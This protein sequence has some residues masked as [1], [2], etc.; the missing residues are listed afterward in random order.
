MDTLPR[1]DVAARLRRVEFLGAEWGLL[2]RLESECGVQVLAVQGM[3]NGRIE[4]RLTTDMAV[5]V[6]T[7]QMPTDAEIRLGRAPF[8]T[9]G[10]LSLIAP[11]CSLK[12][13]GRGPFTSSYCAYSRGFFARLS[14]TESRLRISEF[15]LAGPIESERLTYLGQ[16]MLREAIAP[17]FG[18]AVF[19]EA[20]GIAVAVEIARMDGGRGLYDEPRLGALAPWQMRR[21][22]AYVRANLSDALTLRELAL[23]VGV[24]VRGLSNAVKRSYGV[25]L[26]RWV[27]RQRIA[28]ARRLLDETDLP[29]DEVGRRCAFASV[30]AFSAAFRRAAGCGPGAFRRLKQDKA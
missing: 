11:G 12:L 21:L 3:P 14:E 29:I 6:H 26:N 22:D 30:A 10:S 15:N 28:Q 24:S 2:G 20:M 7:P 9:L 19:A 27:A 18:G 1:T 4:N 13:R 16:A 5:F 23:L 25:G 17:G 8:R